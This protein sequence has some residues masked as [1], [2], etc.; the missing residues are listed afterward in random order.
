[1]VEDE[2]KIWEK[3]FG[4][5]ICSE[6]L[7]IEGF[8][9]PIPFDIYDGYAIC[10]DYKGHRLDMEYPQM[11]AIKDS[12]ELSDAIINYI[13]DISCKEEITV[14][15]ILIAFNKLSVD[16]VEIKPTE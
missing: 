9:K 10:E 5:K 6:K 1:M 8:N 15:H 13:G 14:I 12:K 7:N 16:G 11:K 3:F 2:S 4:K